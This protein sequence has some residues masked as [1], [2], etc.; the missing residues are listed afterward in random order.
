MDDKYISL[1][2]KYLSGEIEDHDRVALFELVDSSGE[3]KAYFEEMQQVWNVSAEESDDIIIDTNLAWQ[4]VTGRIN[5]VVEKKASAQGAKVFRLGQLLKI[6]A[7]FIG[8]IGAV[9]LFNNPR[10]TKQQFTAYQTYSKEKK[11]VLLPDGSKVWLNENS[12]L[13]FDKNFETRVVQ[14]EGEAFFEVQHLVNNHKFEIL[15]GDTKT[16]VLGTSFN[17]RAYSDEAQVEVTVESGRVVF[18][19]KKAKEI[20]K[21]VILKAGDSGVYKKKEA[22]VTKTTRTISNADAW[23]TEKL[24]FKDAKLSEVIEVMERYFD[25]T[26]QANNAKLLN[27]PFTGEYQDPKIDQMMKVLEFSLNI[28][29]NQ[30]E[31]NL[32]F[33][34]EGCE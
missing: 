28:D 2:A 5:P 32:T 12:R 16:T 25:I 4:K 14:L 21:K 9:W 13:S 34:G 3:H 8:V 20:A 22:E 27:C 29:I 15:S 11:E 6:A 24:D 18:E 26:I 31:N 33:S 30:N 7:V 1:I 23:K 17:V 10:Q 19:D